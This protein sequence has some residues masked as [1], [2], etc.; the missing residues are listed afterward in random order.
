[1]SCWAGPGSGTWHVL[2]FNKGKLSE[3]CSKPSCLKVATYPLTL[4]AGTAR[5]LYPWAAWLS[6]WNR[7]GFSRE[8]SDGNTMA[9]NSWVWSQLPSQSLFWKWLSTQWS[10]GQNVTWKHTFRLCVRE[11]ETQVF[12]FGRGKRIKLRC[13]KWILNDQGDGCSLEQMVTS[14]ASDL[15]LGRH[16]GHQA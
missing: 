15:R 13:R 14:S 3:Q 16:T 6:F 7:G 10:R 5:R 2:S 11:T 12:P 1:M 4:A 9:Q 8:G